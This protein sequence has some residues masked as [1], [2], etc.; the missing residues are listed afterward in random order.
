RP[1]RARRRLRRQRRRLPRPLALLRAVIVA[2]WALAGVVPGAGA[3]DRTHV[4]FH[5]DDGR[6]TESSSL[7]VSAAHPGLVYT[8][9]D[10]GDGP[11][12]YVLDRNGGLVGT[13][14]LAG[15]D[16]LD[17]EAMSCGIDGTLV[18]A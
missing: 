15:V 9:N 4:V 13:T 10:S 11:F 8:A 14:T 3:V 18:V 5:I 7:V 1:G 2:C 17:I 16:P 6:I 12:V